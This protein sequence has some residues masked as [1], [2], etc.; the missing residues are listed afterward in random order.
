[1]HLEARHIAAISLHAVDGVRYLRTNLAVV[2]HT[3]QHAVARVL[4]YVVLVVVGIGFPAGLAW[5]LGTA[6]NAQLSDAGFHAAWGFLF[7]GYKAPAVGGGVIAGHAPGETKRGS[8]AGAISDVSPSGTGTGTVVGGTNTLQRRRSSIIDNATA[9][10]CTT[11]GPA[12]ADDGTKPGVVGGPSAAAQGGRGT[13]GGFGHQPVPAVRRRNVVVW[14]LPAAAGE[15]RTIHALAVQPARV[16]E[17]HSVGAHRYHIDCAVAI[18]CGYGNCGYAW[19]NRHDTHR[20]DGHAAAGVYQ[21][22]HILALWLRL[23]VATMPPGAGRHPSD[24]STRVAAQKQRRHHHPSK[25]AERQRQRRSREADEC[26]S[27]NT[28]HIGSGCR[29]EQIE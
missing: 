10:D 3:G 11:V 21:H 28:G 24:V 16:G 22:G 19:T 14:G 18:Q 17:P 13:A 8:I 26:W 15:V 5:M 7:D 23:V 4:A 9:A 29:A 20:M 25:P 27:S 1:M 2:C 12:V 6:T